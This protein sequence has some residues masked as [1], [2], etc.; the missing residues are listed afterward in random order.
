M[1]ISSGRHSLYLQPTPVDMSKKSLLLSGFIL[2]KFLLQFFLIGTEYELHRDEY[3]HIDQGHHLAW[4][5]LSI[6]PFTSWT[7][8]LILLL[9]NSVFWVKFFPALYGALTMY[10]V[11]K[12][13][14]ELNG[15]PFAL[16]LGCT[17]VLF[18]SLLR[19]NIL[20][21]PNSFDVLCW[22]TLY[23]ILLKYYKTENRNWL[24]AGAAVFA[25]GFLNKYNIAFQLAGLAPALLM[26]QQR[27]IF[28]RSAF[29]F[30]VCLG[31]VL[32]LPNLF[33]QY[34]NGFPVIHH[35]QEL[36]RTHLV[37]VKR[38][39]FLVSQMMFFLG[40]TVVLVS[41]LV[42]LLIFEPFRKYRFLFWSFFFTLSIFM[43]LKAKSYYAI[44]IYPIYLSF[45]AVY[46]EQF[47]ERSRKRFLQPVLVAI[48]V[49]LFLV[50]FD[51][52][53]PI[54]SP[55]YITEHT[56]EYKR[57]GMLR[58][59]D[60]KDHLLPQDFADMLGWKELAAKVDSLYARLPDKSKT[61]V[62]C[63]NYGQAGAINYYSRQHIKA[64]TFHADYVNWFDLTIPY[65][66]LIRVKNNGNGQ[67]ELEET[68]P[69]FHRSFLAD[70][71]THPYAREYG[72]T[73]FCFSGAKTDIRARLQHE[74]EE[75]KNSD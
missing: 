48:P 47:I 55:A 15:K 28:T 24:Y 75:V 43:Y 33:W 63:D 16:I 20:Y 35:M 57:L 59:E 54:H 23:F 53:H 39:D 45:G 65:Q 29:Y 37:H 13:I 36:A 74:I 70:S 66:N 49:L 44:G 6:P 14:M 34:N 46:L 25:F 5:Y 2:L 17:C 51:I 60:G 69:I 7:S 71:V 19:L 30:A 38:G 52:V 12:A 8:Y 73:I 22:T 61:L 67:T 58:W 56:E 42:G 11:Y 41:A 40:S 50:S 1:L 3:L 21:Q 18:S 10:V 26:S 72:A 9:G 62:L 68:S 31:F 64:V 32:V 27:T 4:G